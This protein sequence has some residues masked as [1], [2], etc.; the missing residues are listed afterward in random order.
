MALTS[1]GKQ[2]EH[3]NFATAGLDSQLVAMQHIL[4]KTHDAV[5]SQSTAI[6]CIM[7]S[8]SSARTGPVITVEEVSA[9]LFDPDQHCDTEA[10]N[11]DVPENRWQTYMDTGSHKSS[12][13][14]HERHRLIQS[15][16][17]NTNC[18]AKTSK[19]MT[20]S[21]P[22][23]LIDT[24]SNFY[25]ET[26]TVDQRLPRSCL[27]VAS[28]YEQRSSLDLKTNLYRIFYMRYPR[29]WYRLNISIDI[30]RSSAYWAATR[31]TQGEFRTKD[32]T[33]VA[34]G[35]SL[36]LSL[37]TKLQA[38][39]GQGVAF[40]ANADVHFI[41]SQ[42]DKVV[43]E[44][45]YIDSERH[46]RPKLP[47]SLFVDAL[48][49][50]DDLGCPR[51]RQQDVVQIELLDPPNRFLS[52]LSG[53][54]V[55]ETMFAR[56]IPSSGLLY[57]IKV[58]YC[59]RHHPAFAKLIGVVTN[60]S[61]TQLVSYLIEFPMAQSRLQDKMRDPTIPW[62]RREKWARQLVEGVAMVHSKGY[63][64]GNLLSPWVPVVIDESDCVQF[65]YFRQKFI[66]G[67]GE[68]GYYPPEFHHLK[69]YP[70]SIAEADSPN[71]TSKTDM[72]HLGL[73]LWLL[74]E[75]KPRSH[76]APLCIRRQCSGQTDCENRHFSR[77]ALP[78]LPETVP[79]YY[80]EIVDAC[81]SDNI[82]D[83]PTARSLLKRFPRLDEPLFSRAK[84]PT[85]ENT[86][87]RG[88]GKGI[89]GS[90]GCNVCNEFEVERFFH[91]NVCETND[92]DLCYRCYTAGRHCYQEDH[93]LIEMKKIGGW[94]VPWRYHSKVQSSG[95]RDVFEL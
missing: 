21:A 33:E 29:Q 22:T 35:A 3:S 61:Q 31:T 34:A 4:L 70:T 72:Y 14:G 57:T 47:R 75:N 43:S 74:A 32:T 37:L 69:H 91:C 46:A 76:R 87:L 8:V 27:V 51:Y 68:G 44:R 30:P 90:V 85:V 19:Q 81:R 64:V 73:L 95:H 79:Q 65:W 45:K 50:L 84:T 17:Q 48:A 13:T 53:K 58:L 42:Q 83:R 38:H 5:M 88:L 80:R 52:C 62:Q 6:N 26:Y 93:L 89:R 82:E 10:P 63:V 15:S 56:T 16:S 66:V 55:F 92:F 7:E 36:P 60:E 11:D 40:E 54:V 94:K 49:F 9:H 78:S 39:L 2:I 71:L 18:F 25:P 67:R 86:N 59:L 24:S 28:S 1:I 41:L 77:I 23:S 20:A 12:E